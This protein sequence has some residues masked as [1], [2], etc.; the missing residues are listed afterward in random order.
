MAGC[1]EHGNEPSG[2]IRVKKFL[3]Y[4]NTLLAPQGGP[5][6]AVGPLLVSSNM[7]TRQKLY[8]VHSHGLHSHC[9]CL[10]YGK[11]SSVCALMNN[12]KM[13]VTRFV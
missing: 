3:D 13:A 7:N 1:C 12:T 9:T 5:L 11:C 4:L 6:N 10:L 2:P 8:K